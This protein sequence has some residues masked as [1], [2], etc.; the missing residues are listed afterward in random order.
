MI[1][2]ATSTLTPLAPLS[3]GQVPIGFPVVQ[4][5]LSGYSDV[6]M[7][8]IARRL[9]AS[10]CLCEVVLDRL[11]LTG[12]KK[13][14]R[15]LRIADG[16]H[17]VGGQLMGSDPTEFAPAAKELVRAGFD[18]IDINFGC[19][20]KKVLGRCRGGYLLGHPD[21]ALE[22]VS[23]V[24]DAV[25]PGIPVTVKMRRGV[26]DSQ[27]SRDRFFEIFDGAFARGV[28][29][30]TVHGRTVQQRYIGPSRWE[31]LREVKAHA[32]ARTVLGSGDL[33]TPQSCLDMIRQTG[34][35]GVTA[36]RGAI[37]NPWIFSQARALSAGLPLPAPPSLHEQREVMLE[38]YRLAEEHYGPDLC[39][40]Q[41][42]KFGIKYAQLHPA[43]I[44][45]RD[46]FIAVRN[47]RDWQAALDRW[48]S[49]DL[50]GVHP[51]EPTDLAE[52]GSAEAACSA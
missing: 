20:V 42:R 6:P 44:Q 49:E 33:F 48:Y 34:V 5:A 50:P 37:G 38:H 28:S 23:Q 15:F 18:V 3:I 8:V 31:F 45:V 39:G 32:G 12:G 19:P 10:Y 17:P 51:P 24:R 16:E 13:T 2:M 43:G 36:A 22:I 26:D 14:R 9:G 35:D 52:C 4:A 25:P 46:A 47:M 1:D 29:A 40:R 11:V 41:M 21:T 27:Q 7:R 30:I